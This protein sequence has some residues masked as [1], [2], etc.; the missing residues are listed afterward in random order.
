V[1]SEEDEKVGKAELEK[2]RGRG[3]N[4]KNDTVDNK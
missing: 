1:G 2:N 4:A 3:E